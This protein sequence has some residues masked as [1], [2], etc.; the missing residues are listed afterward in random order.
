M[1]TIRTWTRADN[2]DHLSLPS[3]RVAPGTDTHGPR[4]RLTLAEVV[5]VGAD[6]LGEAQPIGHGEYVVSCE[7]LN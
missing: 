2:Q 5:Q 4:A 6:R 1:T 3:E 7:I